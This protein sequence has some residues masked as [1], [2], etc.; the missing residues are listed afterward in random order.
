[1]T[2]STAASGSL[3]QNSKFRV[4]RFGRE[5][6]KARRL[7]QCFSWSSRTECA[8]KSSSSRP[9]QS[10]SSSRSMKSSLLDRCDFVH[11]FLGGSKFLKCF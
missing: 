7:T 9:V 5:R 2:A 3:E 4:T 10:D 1:M 11:R 6:L 8:A